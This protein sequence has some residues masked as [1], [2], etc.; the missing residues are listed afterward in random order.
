[1]KSCIPNFNKSNPQHKFNMRYLRL[2]RQRPAQSLCLLP[3]TSNVSLTVYNISGQAV[4]RF[5]LGAKP[6]CISIDFKP[7]TLSLPGR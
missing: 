6:G 1:M 3:K 4:K 7:G 2:A 5:D